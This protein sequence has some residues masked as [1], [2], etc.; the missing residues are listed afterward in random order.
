MDKNQ[1]KRLQDEFMAYITDV[2]SEALSEAFTIAVTHLNECYEYEDRTFSAFLD[3]V[4]TILI[5]SA[6]YAACQES[7]LVTNYLINFF[8]S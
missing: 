8:R 6:I 3:E 2:E 7:Q 4:R 5:E 1:E